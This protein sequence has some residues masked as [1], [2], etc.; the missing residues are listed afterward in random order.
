MEPVSGS[1]AKD[2]VKVSVFGIDV[3]VPT[4]TL[5]SLAKKL[6][7]SAF[8]AGTVRAVSQW[9]TKSATESAW[10]SLGEYSKLMEVSFR[11]YLQQGIMSKEELDKLNAAISWDKENPP[12]SP[13][14]N[15]FVHPSERR[16]QLA[17]AAL[18][19]LT[20]TQT[21]LRSFGQ[22]LEEN[23]IVRDSLLYR[24]KETWEKIQGVRAVV[25]GHAKLMAE[26]GESI[27]ETKAWEVMA[28]EAMHLAKRFML[29]ADHPWVKIEAY[30]EEGTIF[31]HVLRKEA[32]LKEE[33]KDSF[34]KLGEKSVDLG[35]FQNGT[36][37]VEV[38]AWVNYLD[39][40]KNKDQTLAA[41]KQSKLSWE[42]PHAVAMAL[43]R[44]GDVDVLDQWLTSV[45]DVSQTRGRKFDI[46]FMHHD[47]LGRTLVEHALNDTPKANK[48][49]VVEVLSKHGAVF[50]MQERKGV[51]EYSILTHQIGVQSVEE[52]KQWIN[53]LKPKLRTPGLSINGN[54]FGH[55]EVT[56]AVKNGSFEWAGAFLDLRGSERAPVS[57]DGKTWSDFWS[58]YRSKNPE[59]VS[60]L[61][62]EKP[63]LLA[64]LDGKANKN[65]LTS[66]FERQPTDFWEKIDD[67]LQSFDKVPE[68]GTPK[69]K[70]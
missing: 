44:T 42:S 70:P 23:T 59:K 26:K 28:P 7:K 11:D 46:N 68:I 36:N 61:K 64:Y 65:A 58:D 27:D 55:T 63:E 52:A 37:T 48:M 53:W 38:G 51:S 20:E 45:K 5:G 62:N 54:G 31:K 30:K 34:K 9:R 4:E 19:D 60:F 25:L 57:P 1:V 13:H 47:F 22:Y 17:V 21:P 67:R 8:A 24:A 14:S 16:F 3:E 35:S 39:K 43:V 56:E 6:G 66:L 49:A 50:D 32:W 12:M 10:E 18:N 41:L 40:I 15:T 29:M 2:K 69:R 33:W